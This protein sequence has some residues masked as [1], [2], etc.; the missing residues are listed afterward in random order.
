M[1]H[2]DILIDKDRKSRLV[3]Q[4]IFNSLEIIQS[5]LLPS[6]LG[7]AGLDPSTLDPKIQ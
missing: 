7:P 6:H 5:L 1:S 2:H 3:I 4:L